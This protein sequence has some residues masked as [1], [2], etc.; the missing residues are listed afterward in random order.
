MAKTKPAYAVQRYVGETERLYGVLDTRLEGREYVVGD[1]FSIADISLVGWV[2]S[3]ALA[4]IDLG[5]QFP[6][7]K[8]WLDRLQAR[9]GVQRGLAIP[10][11]S[12]V[13]NAALA[14]KSAEGGEEARQQEEATR[15]LIADA[16][17]EF[18]YKYASP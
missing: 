5:G 9:P 3:S 14:K 2:N 4:G 7:V 17:E 18:G 8:A 1:R 12:P 16:K 11:E 6:N 13:S 10:S 15:K